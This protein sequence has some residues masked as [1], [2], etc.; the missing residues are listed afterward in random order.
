MQQWGWGTWHPPPFLAPVD[1]SQ[2]SQVAPLLL[3][4]VP[5]RISVVPV[6]FLGSPIESVLDVQKLYL[7]KLITWKEGRDR[8]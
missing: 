5:C 8:V 1:L 6:C 3:C 2:V 4:P 7:Y